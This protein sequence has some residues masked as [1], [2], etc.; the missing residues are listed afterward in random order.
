M[1]LIWGYCLKEGDAHF[2][3][4]GTIHMKFQQFIIFSFQNSNKQLP[5]RYIVLKIHELRVTF[6]FL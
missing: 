5:L 2:K 1:A 4:R 3:V 6:T